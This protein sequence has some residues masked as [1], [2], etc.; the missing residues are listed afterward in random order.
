MSTQTAR[1]AKALTP[2]D[3]IARKGGDP[4][5]CL[6]AYTT[7]VAKLVDGHCDLILV[8]DSVGMVV[9]GLD[10][11]LGVTMEMMILHGQAVRRGLRHALMVV[12][13]PFGAY[14][15]G[16]DQAFANA[17]RLVK[18]TGCDAIK[19]EGG[20]HMAETIRFLTERSIPVVAHIGLTP[21]SIRR[22][23]GYKVQ[24]RGD[25]ADHVL[26]DAV[27]VSEAG[28]FA[29]V[30]ESVPESLGTRITEAIA[31]PTIG[32][33]ASATCDGQI[34]VV[35]DMLGMFTDFTPK[36][37]KRYGELAGHAQEA[38]ARYAEEVRTRTFPGPDHVYG[39]GPAK[40]GKT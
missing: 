31:V 21:Q 18:E 6:T 14:E 8:G 13:L 27:A 39:E 17:V 35:D 26:A 22:F 15:A 32:I 9:H 2:P 40:A 12:D 36:F 23:G 20:V 28:A 4:L 11:T 34:L 5:V 29:V 30:V 25:A 16:P 33:G 37:V 19:I 24:G 3:I 38:I 10:N 1:P 7:P